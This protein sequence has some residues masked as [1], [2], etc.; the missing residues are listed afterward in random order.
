MARYLTAAKLCTLVLVEVYVNSTQ[1][2]P[3]HG[4]QILSLIA[5]LLVSQY[6]PSSSPQEHT[7]PPIDALVFSE[8]LS[9][10]PSNFPGRN[11]RDDFIATLWSTAS[12]DA[13]HTLFERLQSLLQPANPEERLIS[14]GSP[15]G[16]FV[17]RSIVEWTRLPFQAS[18]TLLNAF[19]TYIEPTWSALL[20][21]DPETARIYLL[22]RQDTNARASVSAALSNS[23]VSD[24]RSPAISTGDVEAALSH[25]V[26]LL[27]SRG[28][29]IPPEL[30]ERLR[31][32]LSSS[33]S[34]DQGV[35]SLHHFLCFFE[36]WRAGQYNQALE[37][38]HRYF[39]YSLASKSAPDNGNGDGNGNLKLYYQYALLHLSV[40]H[41]DFERWEESLN[42]ME[43]CVAT[44]RES[45]DTVC[46][47]FALSWLLYLRQASSASSFSSS[48]SGGR[49]RSLAA[50]AGE[51]GSEHD[52][53]AFLKQKAKESRHWSLV[54]GTLLEEAK[55]DLRQGGVTP[56]SLES[57]LQAAHL[58]VQHA[59]FSLIPA[60][61]IF[62]GGILERLGISLSCP[63][64]SRSVD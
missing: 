27:Q 17:R 12:L 41:A 50:L 33:T 23:V 56:K 37:N 5:D 1:A 59:N 11:Y 10:I 48:E 25:S 31:T 55:L 28:R 64:A 49:T 45:Q 20:R 42:A 38:L 63:T 19:T 36:S 13:L 47:S 2:N 16:H 61:S 15:T 46:L 60:T 34:Q 14:P 57:V 22:Q 43:E 54:S 29:R 35:Q 58:N 6:A 4:S 26:Y 3:D 7:G 30:R 21:R 32:W 51:G 52:E 53:L 40:L 39:D 8:P 44:A 62:M 24:A 9:S 18:V